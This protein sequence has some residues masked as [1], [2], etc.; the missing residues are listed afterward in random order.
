ML[1]DL[2]KLEIA[3]PLKCEMCGHYKLNYN[4]VGE[5]QCEQCG[6]VMYDDYGIVR[7]YLEKNPGATQSEVSRATGVSG[8][9][10]RRML[11]DDKIQIAPGSMVF[12]H[13]EKCGKEIR[14]G[15]LCNNCLKDVKS[16]ALKQ[17]ISSRSKN[18][19]IVGGFVKR[20]SETMGSMRYKKDK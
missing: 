18:V 19:N 15:R 10:I 1:N 5:Y 14:S 3:T 9:M 13:C 12:L 16:D 2:E 8:A 7:N 20:K 17:E 11:R 6:Y 4:G